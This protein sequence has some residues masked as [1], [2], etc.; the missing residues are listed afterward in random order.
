FPR[1]DLPH[2][3]PLIEERVQLGERL[4]HETALSRDGTLSCSS[5]HA[6]SAAFADPR[7]HSIG[8]RGQRGTRN[9]M[10][11]FNLA[12]KTSFFWD[13]RAPSLRAQVLMPIVD[14]T[15]MD[16]TLDR[17]ISKLAATTD[18]PPLFRAAFG[19]PEITAEKL[20]LA[21]EQFLLTLTA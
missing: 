13:G 19:G 10:P 8:V 5:C 15:E 7:R 12:W 21:L 20:G 11:L 18:Y 2:D 16:E 4:F 17:V 14:H 6:A 1:P 3:N 9:S